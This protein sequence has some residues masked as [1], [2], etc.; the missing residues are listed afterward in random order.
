MTPAAPPA[1][2]GSR[3]GR[4]AWTFAGLQYA[5]LVWFGVC[6]TVALV[7]AADFAGHV[8]LP[9]QGDA[10]TENVEVFSGWASPFGQPMLLT[11][12][13]QPVIAFAAVVATGI[14]L[15]QAKVRASRPLFW[16]ILVGGILVFGTFLLAELPPGRSVTN[17]ILD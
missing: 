8:Y 10:Y 3:A 5:Y 17:W 12:L 15:V 2:A 14:H 13:L 16:A 1:V 7:R 6:V 11:A 4:G 9:Y